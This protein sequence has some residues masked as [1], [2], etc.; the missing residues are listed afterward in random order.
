[1]SKLDKIIERFLSNPPD[2][3][4]GD[5]CLLLEAY[6]FEKK[7]QTGSHNIFRNDEGDMITVPTVNGRTVKRTYVKQIVR[8]LNLNGIDKND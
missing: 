5:V 1:M 8:L 3:R 2:V 7:R 6:G 4:F